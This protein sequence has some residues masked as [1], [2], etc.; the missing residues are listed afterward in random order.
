MSDAPLPLPRAV[1][2][3]LLKRFAG[4][5][6]KIRVG[7]KA[8][9]A[10]NMIHGF[11]VQRGGRGRYA[12]QSVLGMHS[13]KLGRAVGE[14]VLLRFVPIGEDGE[15]G[16]EKDYDHQCDD[17]EC[18]A[19]KSLNASCSSTVI[20]F[21]APTNTRPIGSIDRAPVHSSQFTVHSS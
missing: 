18:A 12:G 11:G 19:C 1:H 6:S 9:C 4:P 16:E 5:I 20:P 8:D 15:V 21:S 2:A 7:D 3:L 17:V 10:M 13:F 14:K